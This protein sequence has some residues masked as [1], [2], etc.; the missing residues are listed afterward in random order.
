ME[1]EN[2]SSLKKI[3]TFFSQISEIQDRFIM[4]NYSHAFSDILARNV[5]NLRKQYQV[6]NF[7]D[8]IDNNTGVSKELYS[9]PKKLVIETI[10]FITELN[11]VISLTNFIATTALEFCNYYIKRSDIKEL[12]KNL[13]VHRS[14]QKYKKIRK[15]IVVH[16]LSSLLPDEIAY[17]N[18]IG[19]LIKKRYITSAILVVISDQEYGISNLLDVSYTLDLPFTMEDYETFAG[20]PLPNPRMLEIVNTLGIK[21]INE[22]EQFYNSDNNIVLKSARDIINLLIKNKNYDEISNQLNY[23]LKVCSILFEEFKLFD[24]ENLEKHIRISYKDMLPASLEISLLETS[25][26]HTYHFTENIF[27]KYYRYA[28][29]ILIEKTTYLTIMDYLKA[30]YPT[31]YADLALS[32][33]VMP[34][35]EDQCLSYFIIAYYH[36]KK[37]NLKFHTIIKEKLESTLLGLKF[38][39]LEIQKNYP[40]SFTRDEILQ[41][42][43]VVIELIKSNTNIT[44]E[45][46]LCILSY[47]ADLMYSIEDDMQQL[48][49]VFDLYQSIFTEIHLFSAPKKLYIDYVLDAIAFSTAIENYNVQKIADR[50][51][52]WLDLNRSEN[53][54]TMIKFYKLGNL[55]FALNPNK[56]KTYTKLAFELSKNNIILHEETRI[57]YSVSLLGLREY[58]KAYHLLMDCKIIAPD[59]RFA[60]ENNKYIAGYLSGHY[61]ASKLAK[62]FKE[63]VASDAKSLTGDY[64]IILN[65]Y[66]AALIVSG[67]D[68]NYNKIIECAKLLLRSTD[69][70]HI[71]YTTH[72]LMVCS[73]LRNDINGFK[74]HASAIKIP[75]LLRKQSEIIKMKI[76]IMEENWGKYNTTE[77][78]TKVLLSFEDKESYAQNLYMLPVLWGPLERWFK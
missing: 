4:I 59:Y 32:S 58:E 72:N 66:M 60:L 22:L 13:H 35:S 17:L 38:L 73:Y 67:A 12:R 68:A 42:C 57:N 62:Q 52:E 54:D 26:M 39:K 47:I 20:S 48:M 19:Y 51:I 46:R 78:L 65:N 5:E 45:A 2:S 7:K 24:L 64:P 33:L 71:F 10:R 69:P 27:R 41:E 49:Q 56:S 28:G 23:F 50:L 14:P 16:D 36:R 9:L 21:C 30:E 25:K 8:I 76:L 34:I 53:Y 15:V 63:L 31:Q 29:D 1:N 44:S 75:Y 74:D 55:L 61:N 18:F 37:Q 70:Y 6:I 77:A 43:N 40:K 11:P 3:E